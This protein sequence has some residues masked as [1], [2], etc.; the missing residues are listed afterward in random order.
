M[1]FRFSGGLS[2]AE[3]KELTE[4]Y[5]I[6]DLPAPKRVVIPLKQ[7]TGALLEPLVKKGDKVKIGDKIGD[8]KAF[9]SS[10]IHSS[11]S[12]KVVSI[13]PH[14]IPT[15]E[16]VP[17]IIIEEEESDPIEELTLLKRNWQ[18]LDKGEII[19]IIR[20]SGIVGLGGAA[21]PTSVKLS[22]PE[23]TTIDTV[24]LNGAEC[25]P[26]LTC[27]H[28]L[29]VEYPEEVLTGL[30]IIMKA[31]G[32]KQGI[33]GIEDNKP[34]AI[35]LLT[36]KAKG[37]GNIKIISLPT[38]YPQGSEKHL[39]KAILNREVPSGKLPLNV[40]VVVNNVGT[41]FSIT[42]A[43]CEGIPL[44][45][46]VITVSGEGVESPGN[47][48]VRIGTQFKEILSYAGLKPEAKKV[49]SGGP[50]TGVAQWTLDV[51]VIK[52]TSG[53]IALTEVD[54]EIYPCLRCA[55]CVDACPMG[56]LPVELGKLVEDKRYDDAAKLYI[57]DCIECGSC[58]Y[59]CPSRRPLVQLFKSA[60]LEILKRRKK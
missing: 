23:G 35:R 6:K 18:E 27:D 53:I 47:F 20:D 50:M 42:K 36:E 57:M 7:H 8:S 25:E 39:I 2:I 26:Y 41:A 32:A 19:R 24:I 51:P 4:S 17:S 33:I 45:S 48:R 56:L 1:V 49:I 58:A 28:R 55:R 13:E 10:P 14:P 54:D 12:G 31:V 11:I 15:G 21:F 34:E 38:R 37:Y 40:G 59:I 46:R 16:T 43:V 9:V 44:I 52:G 30:E 3:H 29:M 5:S 22:P 60:K